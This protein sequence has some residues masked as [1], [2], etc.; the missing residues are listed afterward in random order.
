MLRCALFYLLHLLPLRCWLTD[1]TFESS[2]PLFSSLT[3]TYS[4]LWRQKIHWIMFR[5]VSNVFDSLVL[6]KSWRLECVDNNIE[7]SC[8]ASQSKSFLFSASGLISCVCGV[9]RNALAMPSLHILHPHSLWVSRKLIKPEMDLGLR[10]EPWKA[11]RYE[12]VFACSI[13]NHPCGN[14]VQHIHKR[15]KKASIWKQSSRTC[16]WGWSIISPWL[17]TVRSDNIKESKPYPHYSPC[18]YLN[19]L[20]HPLLPLLLILYL[21]AYL[22]QINM[23]FQATG[24]ANIL[25]WFHSSVLSLVITVYLQCVSLALA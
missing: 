2:P 18:C 6:S 8:V 21:S 17:R 13:H 1:I 22:W 3:S 12:G 20:Y 7:V 4:L 23:I 5:F 25:M 19:V 11:G 16:Q 24:A 10:W 14:H 9:L 15:R